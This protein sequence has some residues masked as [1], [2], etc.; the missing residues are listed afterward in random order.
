MGPRCQKQ[1]E[2]ERLSGC[3]GPPRLRQIKT[4]LSGR[5]QSHANNRHRPAPWF[6]ETSPEGNLWRPSKISCLSVSALQLHTF[7]FLGTCPHSASRLYPDSISAP[8]LVPGTSRSWDLALSEEPQQRLLSWWHRMCSA[9]SLCFPAPQQSS[10]HLSRD[11][12]QC[13][14][15][16]SLR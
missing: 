10:P 8:R 3:V 14:L 15:L 12:Q 7:Q 9:C 1:V 6:G 5:A 4:T 2:M 16:S 13:F 11:A